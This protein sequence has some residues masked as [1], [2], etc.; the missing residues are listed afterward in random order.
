MGIS[1]FTTHPFEMTSHWAGSGSKLETD[2]INQNHILYQKQMTENAS[3]FY[4]SF[5]FLSSLLGSPLIMSDGNF[6]GS[7][8]VLKILMISMTS[9]FGRFMLRVWKM[10]KS[11][12]FLGKIKHFIVT[13]SIEIISFQL[14][15]DYGRGPFIGNGGILVLLGT[16]KMV[17][18]HAAI[19]V[20]QYFIQ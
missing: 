10:K 17:N 18:I 9:F 6:A 12:W 8:L 13:C 11:W 1:P 3:F 7:I 5:L 4:S 15:S 20:I 19:L 2:F 16:G 14:S